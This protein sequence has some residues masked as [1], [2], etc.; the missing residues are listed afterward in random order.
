M[1]ERLSG[2]PGPK[3]VAIE[4]SADWREKIDEVDAALIDGYQGGFPVEPRPFQTV[5]Q[6]LGISEAGILDRIDALLEAGILRRFGPVC[7]PPVIGASTLAA[8]RAPEENF[9]EVVTVVNEFPQVNHNYRRDHEWNVWFVVTAGSL[10]RRDEILEAIET[11]TGCELL[12]LPMH[13]DYYIDLAFPVVNRDRFARE[14]GESADVTPTRIGESAAGDLSTLEAKLLL[15]IQD[16]LPLSRTPYADVAATLD[17]EPPVVR[18]A[19]E[20]LLAK[21][22]VKR[23]GVVVNHRVTGFDSNCMVVWDVPDEQLDSCGVAAG[24]LPSVTLCYHRPRRPEQDWPYNLFTMIHGREASAVEDCIDALE[25][26]VLPYDH[27]RLQTTA[28]LK[29]TGARYEALVGAGGR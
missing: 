1:S 13:T 25:A 18:D 21:R 14:H 27:A 2:E 5:G 29:Q 19:L 10:E 20:K 9:E 12:N 3:D 16:G 17:T 7:N 24:T 4:N 23:I 22:C 11:R 15:E 6:E 28:T 8:I 26:E